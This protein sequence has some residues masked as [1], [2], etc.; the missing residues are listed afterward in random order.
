MADISDVVELEGDKLSELSSVGLSP[1]GDG[2]IELAPAGLAPP[3]RRKSFSKL[4][5]RLSQTFRF[6]LNGSMAEL[7]AGFNDRSD[8][9]NGTVDSVKSYYFT[10]KEAKLITQFKVPL[11][12]YVINSFFPNFT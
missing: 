11:F 4:R 9:S 8:R 7:S 5:R 1:S 6:S 3:P 2:G 12:I 10:K